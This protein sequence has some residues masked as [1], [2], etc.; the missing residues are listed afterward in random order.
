MKKLLVVIAAVALLTGCSSGE[1]EDTGSVVG[2]DAVRVV[3]IRTDD[4][5]AVN[6]ATWRHSIDCDWEGAR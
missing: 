4:G 6:C 1:V 2:G 3:T 5:K